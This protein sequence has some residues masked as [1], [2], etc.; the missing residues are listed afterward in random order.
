[1]NALWLVVTII[2]AKTK[3]NSAVMA[4]MPSL[5]LHVVFNIILLDEDGSRLGESDLGRGREFDFVCATATAISTINVD[6]ID[7]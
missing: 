1:M 6:C 5:F 2:I 7:Y 4:C 3:N